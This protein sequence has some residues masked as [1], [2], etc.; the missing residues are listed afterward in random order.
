MESLGVTAGGANVGVFPG[1]GVN[2]GQTMPIKRWPS[3]S[4]VS[5]IDKILR[6]SGS[7]IV[8]VGGRDDVGL[9]DAIRS[10]AH[11]PGRVVNVAGRFSISEF[12]ALCRLLDGFVGGDSG[13][14][15]I[16]AAVGTPTL[17]L[18]GPSDPR[19]VAPRGEKFTYVWNRVECSPCYTP[20]S[21]MDGSRFRN[22]EFFCRT[23]THECMKDLQVDRVYDSL[24]SVISK[25][26]VV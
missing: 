5:L 21:V 12:T 11:D 22:G 18:F 26:G 25:P 3:V 23:G 24:R 19:L 1:G 17:S 14:T 15:H 16:A 6:N 8:L 7:R 10:A 4:Y 13:P 20:I 9:N 2:P